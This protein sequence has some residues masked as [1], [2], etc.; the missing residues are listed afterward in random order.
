[1]KAV[2]A[3]VCVF[4]VLLLEACGGAAAAVTSTTGASVSPTSTESETWFKWSCQHVAY[5]VIAKNPD[6]YTGQRFTFRGKVMQIEES[7]SKT[8]M[9]VEVT[10]DS[11]DIWTDLIAVA[12]E[13]SVAVYEDDIVEV[14]GICSGSFSYDTKMGGSNSVPGLLATYAMPSY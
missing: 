5:K 8:F 1:M 7:E 2:C 6:A 10:K 9:L 11:Y 14:W 13:G 12:Y 4:A 3:V